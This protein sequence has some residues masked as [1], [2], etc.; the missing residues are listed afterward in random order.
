[1]AHELIGVA[2]P[3]RVEDGVAIDGDRILER[4][5]ERIAGPPQG[6]NVADESE[7]ARAGDIAPE[8]RRIKIEH[9]ALAANR[10]RFEVDLDVEAEA[11]FGGEEFGKAAL[12]IHAH[13]LDDLEIAARPALLDDANRIDRSDKVDGGAVHDR[14]LRPIDLDQ[15]VV[16]PKPRKRR[17]EMFDGRDAGARGVADRSAKRGLRHVG[18]LGL[19]QALASAGQSRAEESDAGVD[20]GRMK[21]KLSGRRGVYADALDDHPIAQRCLRPKPH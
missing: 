4:G 6:L 5:A 9:P 18:A 13:R 10:R 15:D 20:M 11:A 19:E 8:S 14:R 3:F 12:M 21:D 2:E 1:M 17:Q 7:R 16:N